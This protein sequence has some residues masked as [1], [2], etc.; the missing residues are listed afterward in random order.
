MKSEEIFS[1][2]E[3]EDKEPEMLESREILANL[4]KI[5]IGPSG[6][7]SVVKAGRTD[8]E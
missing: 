3:D 4:L 7:K 5:K 1:K 6:G 8:T 2:L